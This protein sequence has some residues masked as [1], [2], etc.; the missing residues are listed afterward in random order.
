MMSFTLFT[1]LWWLKVNTLA[2][3]GEWEELEKL[4]RAKKSPI[5]YE[6]FVDVCLQ[7]G[8]AT[9]AAR[10][11][12]KVDEN[13]QVKYYVKAK[14]YSEAAAIAFQRKDTEALHYIQTRCASQRETVDKIN[15]LIAKLAAPVQQ[16]AKR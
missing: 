15:A 1:R 9:E 13:F 4:S 3:T 10:Y 14:L 16:Q 7:Y 6:P 2:E 12:P 11:L 5:G 8:N